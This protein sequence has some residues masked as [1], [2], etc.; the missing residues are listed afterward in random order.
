MHGG[1]AFGANCLGRLLG[2][3]DDF[4]GIDDFHGST[5]G[6]RMTVEFALDLFFRPYQQHLDVIVTRS[7][8][9]PFH[10]RFRGPV[11]THC[12]HS[13]DGLH[14]KRRLQRAT[15]WL[16]WSPRFPGHCNG[17]S[18]DR[19]DEAI[20]LFHGNWDTRRVPPQSENHE[21]GASKSELSSAAVWDLA[22]LKPFLAPGPGPWA[23]I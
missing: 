13:D 1:I 3:T 12:V 10:F 4:R 21:R 20:F 2:H 23:L 18:G 6:G 11:R 7:Q 17:R 15:S 16:P 5:A 22:S 8:Q 14:G 9:Y 19:R